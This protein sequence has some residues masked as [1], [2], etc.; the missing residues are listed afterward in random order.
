MKQM[1][2]ALAL[3]SSLSIL[4][5]EA[6]RISGAPIFVLKLLASSFGLPIS[7]ESMSL[8]CNAQAFLLVSSSNVVFII[9]S[10]STNVVFCLYT[11]STWK[12]LF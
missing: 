4:H 3:E 1:I 11:T 7:A 6:N 12:R 5:A 9:S 10:L 8:S 2:T